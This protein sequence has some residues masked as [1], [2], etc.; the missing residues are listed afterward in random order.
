MQIIVAANFANLIFFLG[1]E[2]VCVR[3]GGGRAK[4]VIVP[5]Q[6][7]KMWITHTRHINNRR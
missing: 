7:P 5:V 1:R 2:R 3:G 4:R 6:G